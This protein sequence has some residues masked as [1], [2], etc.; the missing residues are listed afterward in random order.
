MPK[1]ISVKPEEV[2]PSSSQSKWS[3]FQERVSSLPSSIYIVA[4]LCLAISQGVLYISHIGPLTIPDHNLHALG[5][6]SLATGQ[7]FNEYVTR[8]DSYGNEHKS[9]TLEGSTAFLD[10][11]GHYEN[12]VEYLLTSSFPYD[13]AFEKQYE[14]ATSSTGITTLPDTDRFSDTPDSDAYRNRANQYF[15]LAWATSALGIHLGITFDMNAFDTWQLGRITNFI[16][17]LIIFSLAIILVPRMKLLVLGIGA[18]PSCVFIGSSLMCDGLI[19]A[20]CTLAVCLT[21]KAMLYPNEIPKWILASI[22]AIGFFLTLVKAVYVPVCLGFILISGSKLPLKRKLWMLSF[23]AIG[24]LIYLAW[25]HQFSDIAVTVNLADNRS[26]ISADPL[27]AIGCILY[28]IMNLPR[29]IY[30]VAQ[31]Q[32][33]KCNIVLLLAIIFITIWLLPKKRFCHLEVLVGA[34]IAFVSSLAIS[35]FFL[36]L[37]WN[38]FASMGIT[39]PIE[40]LQVR[41]LIPLVPL[42]LFAQVFLNGAEENT[43]TRERPFDSRKSKKIGHSYPGSTNK[44]N[45]EFQALK[46]NLQKSANFLA[47][48]NIKR[49]E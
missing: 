19:F 35:L 20:L 4:F 1:F 15:P 49:A 43:Q 47:D 2:N 45:R 42:I 3:S 30:E 39:T 14:A 13:S 38:D 18:L 33:T 9:Q 28:N 17:Y 10:L 16:F 23:I 37:T 25:S 22:V 32:S 41:Y 46:L 7:S 29:F 6:Y 26:A 11:G 21:I 48:P 40:G 44:K 36:L 27:R 5:S 31:V 12:L 8:I 34:I 24:V